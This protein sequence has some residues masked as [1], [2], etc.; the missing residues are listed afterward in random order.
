LRLLH[1]GKPAAG[2]NIFQRVFLVPKPQ[3]YFLDPKLQ[4]GIAIFCKALALRETGF[5]IKCVPK[6]SL[7]TSS[8]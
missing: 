8:N 6:Q 2:K 5:V 3:L 4:L 7:G 1:E